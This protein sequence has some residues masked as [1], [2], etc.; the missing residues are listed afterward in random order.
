MTPVLDD[1]PN[2]LFEGIVQWLD[3]SDIYNLRSSSRL[4]ASKATQHHFKSFFRM[5]QV[6][7]DERSLTYFAHATQPAGCLVEELVLVGLVYDTQVLKDLE[8]R[9]YF[10]SGRR[11][12]KDERDRMQ[13]GLEAIEERRDALRIFHDS[14][15]AVR[16]L[17]E[18]LRNLNSNGSKAGCLSFLS[19]EIRTCIYDGERRKPPASYD[20]DAK[21]GQPLKRRVDLNPLYRTTAQNFRLAMNSLA[22]SRLKVQKLDLYNGTDMQRCSLPCPELIHL[23][24]R[25]PH[26]RACFASVTSLSLSLR[27]PNPKFPGSEHRI[28]FEQQSA[29]LQAETLQACDDKQYIGLPRLLNTMP[30]L[31]HL[32]LHYFGGLRSHPHA[33]ETQPSSSRALSDAKD[34]W[35]PI[36]DYLTS[37][38]A[39]LESLFLDD[40]FETCTCRHLW[41]D[42]AGRRKYGCDD[43]FGCSTVERQGEAVR[44]PISYF[45]LDRGQIGDSADGY[46][47]WK[48]WH[49]FEYEA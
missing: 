25:W 49:G 35:R 5:K 14:K 11:L 46:N 30:K 9:I 38:Q 24:A 13:R 29:L 10:G 6:D 32:D 20:H 27:D 28:P 18:A 34:M 4:L 23:E 22:R 2:E 16:L 45:F 47:L 42:G 48:Q 12:N 37:P 7:L 17:S 31:K 44:L 8:S 19:L 1:L 26:L 15:N 41:F 36:L 33:G 3:L 40:L 21:T 43:V 39:G